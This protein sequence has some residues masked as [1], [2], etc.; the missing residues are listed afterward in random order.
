MQDMLI[1]FGLGIFWLL[2]KMFF[3]KFT[4]KCCHLEVYLQFLEKVFEKV[5]WNFSLPFKI[6]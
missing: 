6:H 3:L 1:S 5:F 2:Q 4:K